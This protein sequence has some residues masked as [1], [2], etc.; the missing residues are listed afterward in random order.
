MTPWWG[1]GG[2]LRGHHRGRAPVVEA[3]AGKG[4]RRQLVQ[5]FTL[6]LA[7]TLLSEKPVPSWLV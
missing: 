3:K 7:L 5:N 6:R 2:G 4:P 1:W